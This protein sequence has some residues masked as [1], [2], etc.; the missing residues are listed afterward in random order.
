LTYYII[1]STYIWLAKG[2]RVVTYR[3]L[4]SV[5]DYWHTKHSFIPEEVGSILVSLNQ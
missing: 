4:L 1:Y 3:K 5:A 2:E